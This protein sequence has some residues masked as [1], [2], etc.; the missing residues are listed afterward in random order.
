MNS[1]N[2]IK[3]FAVGVMIFS[4]VLFPTN[5]RALAMESIDCAIPM[6]D[7][8]DLKPSTM[9]QSKSGQAVYEVTDEKEWAKF[10][11]DQ[12]ES[13]KLLGV[14]ISY[15]NHLNTNPISHPFQK[16]DYGYYLKN[17]TTSEICG[18]KELRSSYYTGPGEATITVSESIAATWEASVGVSAEVISAELG[19]T[20]TSTYSVSDSYSIELPEGETVKIVARPVYN[21]YQYDVWKD[22]L[23]GNDYYLG[24]G[25]AYKPVGVCFYFY[26]V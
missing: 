4:A 8:N 20:V 16:I 23:I 6:I 12:L 1:L 24:S 18:A 5:D 15:N 13:G 26:D 9:I 17:I 14:A 3:V 10:K 25:S 22:P 11:N 2:F 7:K 19:F 21:V